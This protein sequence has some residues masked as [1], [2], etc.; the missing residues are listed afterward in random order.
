MDGQ[1]SMTQAPENHRP[2]DFS[3]LKIKAGWCAAHKNSWLGKL[4]AGCA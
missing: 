4:G 1:A 2:A 3:V